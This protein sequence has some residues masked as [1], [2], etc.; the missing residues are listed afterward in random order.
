MA[1]YNGALECVKLLAPLETGLQTI[2]DF[3]QIPSRSTAL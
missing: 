3:K 1:A 2:K